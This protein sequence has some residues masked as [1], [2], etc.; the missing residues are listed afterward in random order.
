MQRMMI[1]RLIPVPAIMVLAGLF[2]AGLAAAENGVKFDRDADYSGYKVYDW[3]EQKK[4]P[5]GS[6]LAVGGA[7]DTKIR[8]AIDRQLAAQGFSQAIDQEPDF[9]V[10]FDGALEQVTDI[11]SQ[12]YKIASGVSWVAEGDINSYGKG[13]LIITILDAGT[14]KT[15]WSAWTRKKVKNPGSSDK[16][17]EK[18]I[19]QLLSKFPP[20]L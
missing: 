16:R 13:T 8:N 11:Q 17:I 18:T 7:L 20:K 10:S 5:E 14:D 9:L 3:I 2:V 12:R 15:I 6:P 4:R 19:K 1:S